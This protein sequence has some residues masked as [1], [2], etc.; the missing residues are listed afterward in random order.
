MPLPIAEKSSPIM[1]EHTSPRV[2]RKVKTQAAAN[3]YWKAE[4]SPSILSEHLVQSF[5]RD[6]ASHHLKLITPYLYKSCQDK[7]LGLFTYPGPQYF[8]PKLLK[9]HPNIDLVDVSTLLLQ[10]LKASSSKPITQEHKLRYLNECLPYTRIPDDSYDLLIAVDHLAGMAPALQKLQALEYARVIK[11]SGFL[12]FT[13]PL[14]PKTISPA[15]QCLA[16]LSRYLVPLQVFQL[17]EKIPLSLN[18]L[19]AATGLT[20]SYL[21]KSSSP[22]KMSRIDLHDD[23]SGLFARRYGMLNQCV[24]SCMSLCLREFIAHQ[25]FISEEYQHKVSNSPQK[26]R[27]KTVSLDGLLDAKNPRYLAVL[28]GKRTLA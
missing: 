3:S 28:F 24:T 8:E 11:R 13:T 22:Q 5:Y 12:W 1:T 26:C 23:R 2:Q 14:D 10:H 20:S 16:L 15:E 25:A 17:C 21:L 19:E 27:S 18:T 7:S 4:L 6:W 9:S